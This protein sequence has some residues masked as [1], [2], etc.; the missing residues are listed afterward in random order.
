MSQELLFV[1]VGG[2]GI[3]GLVIAIIGFAQN[4]RTL[5]ATQPKTEAEKMSIDIASLRSLLDEERAT[6]KADKSDAQY[7]IAELK[8]E[9][10][11][12]DRK[13]QEKMNDL[14]AKVEAYLDINSV[15]RPSWWPP[16]HRRGA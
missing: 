4:K 1:L 2:P 15:A 7:R 16:H 13:H 6:R 12:Q 10:V 9:L 14:I 8:A 11:E 3:V 5:N